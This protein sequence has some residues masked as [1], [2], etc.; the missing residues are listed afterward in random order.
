MDLDRFR[1]TLSGDEPPDVVPALRALWLLAA[2]DDWDGA[3]DVVN[4]AGGADG[5]WVHAHLHRVEG[6]LSNAD[7]WYR[8]AGRERPGV[9]TDEEWEAIAA[10][11]LARGA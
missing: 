11:L 3:H 8:R 9:P 1:A 6:D 7:F 10:E 2:R 4:R 5:A